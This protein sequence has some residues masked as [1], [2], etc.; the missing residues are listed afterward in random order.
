MSDIKSPDHKEKK[1]K[2]YIEEK[3]W[4]RPSSSKK[5]GWQLNSQ[6]EMESPSTVI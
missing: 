6:L 5:Q 3:V 2:S 1:K 4:K